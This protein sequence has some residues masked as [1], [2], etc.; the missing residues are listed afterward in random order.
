MKDW[1]SF[2]GNLIDKFDI[3]KLMICAFAVLALMVV[4]KINFLKFLMP[5]DNAEKWI[6]FVFA[7]IAT[8]LALLVL[9]FLWL[10]I[11]NYLK[12]TP[13]N[14]FWTM[15]KYG[16]YI[17]MFYSVDIGEYSENTIELRQHNVSQDVINKLCEKNII[18]SCGY[19]EYLNHMR[20]RLTKKARKK[21]TRIRKVINFIDRKFIN[22]KKT[23]DNKNE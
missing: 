4:P 6:I 20:Y 9:G 10:H 23:E 12:Y 8:Y 16:E 15:G 3:K 22:K 7:M 2:F 18:E 1:T 5:L 11:R 19:C 14:L 21:L 17:N 13:K